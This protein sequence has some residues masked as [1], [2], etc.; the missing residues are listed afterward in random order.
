MIAM[1]IDTA[2][3]IL[4]A[5][6]LDQSIEF[7]RR[8]GFQLAGRAPAPEDYALLRREHM[9]LHLFGAPE[10]DPGTCYAAVYLRVTDATQLH[11]EFAA[12]GLPAEGIPRLSSLESKPWGMREFHVVDPSGVLLRVGD[13]NTG[14]S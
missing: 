1:L 11:A 5:L 7:Y 4:P 14:E 2:I 13:F 6:D 3:P 9:E 12:L 8:L 10:L